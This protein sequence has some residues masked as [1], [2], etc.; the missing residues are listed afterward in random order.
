LVIVDI[1]SRSEPSGIEKCGKSKTAT[2]LQGGSIARKKEK[3]QMTGSGDKP[4][5]LMIIFEGI[6]ILVS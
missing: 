5:P 6:E 3:R 1:V 4:I 2:S